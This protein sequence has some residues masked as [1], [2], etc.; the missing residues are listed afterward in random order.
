MIRARYGLRYH[1]LVLSE[2]F[3][4]NVFVHCDV[5]CVN[6]P[7]QATL[8]PVISKMLLIR[9]S[10][11]F[12]GSPP[13]E[14][15][16]LARSLTLVL[17]QSV[18]V[19]VGRLCGHFIDHVTVHGRSGT[20]TR[21]FLSACWCTRSQGRHSSPRACSATPAQTSCLQLAL[22]FPLWWLFWHALTPC[23][24]SHPPVSS[25]PSTGFSLHGLGVPSPIITLGCPSRL[26]RGPAP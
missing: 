18:I 10:A 25:T 24:C 4:I 6:A 5:W 3:L 17:D 16:S 20:L 15:A 7:L 19:L 9:L 14:T 12:S 11:A 22:L 2:L 13:H 21:S 8:L 23:T 1:L 26:M